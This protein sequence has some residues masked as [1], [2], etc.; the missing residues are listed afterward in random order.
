VRDF[1][2]ELL[3]FEFGTCVQRRMGRLIKPCVR[4]FDTRLRKLHGLDTQQI[5]FAKRAAYTDI[6]FYNAELRQRG[7]L[8]INCLFVCVPI[9]YV[10]VWLL[11]NTQIQQILKTRLF[12]IWPLG[13]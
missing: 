11:Q 7:F 9:K 12:L 6:M 10:V 4:A 13:N 8:L 5:P 3:Q 2:V 1:V